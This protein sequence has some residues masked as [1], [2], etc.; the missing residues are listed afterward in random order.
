MTTTDPF[1]PAP[2]IGQVYLL[3]ASDEPPTPA[4]LEAAAPLNAVSE[5]IDFP[6]APDTDHGRHVWK[7]TTRQRWTFTARINH[8]EGLRIIRA[9]V[10]PEKYLHPVAHLTKPSTRRPGRRSHRRKPR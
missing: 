7:L 6:G 10:W 8:P 5:P 2:P 9:L 3:P 4:G 1:R